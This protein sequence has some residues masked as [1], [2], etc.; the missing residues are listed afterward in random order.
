MLELAASVEAGGAG[1]KPPWELEDADG[2]LATRG[3]C[4]G[5]EHHCPARLGQV[6]RGVCVLQPSPHAAQEAATAVTQPFIS[7]PQK[8]GDCLLTGEISTRRGHKKKINQ[9]SW[10]MELLCGLHHLLLH[11][12]ARDLGC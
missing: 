10:V 1:E 7:L 11:P 2:A 9:L 5:L 3:T 6:D 4:S 8:R 12:P